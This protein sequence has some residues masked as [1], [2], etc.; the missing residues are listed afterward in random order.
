MRTIEGVALV[1]GA[2]AG[3]GK[4]AALALGARGARVAVHYMKS[5]DGAEDVVSALK[6]AGTDAHAFQG[7]LTK[8]AGVQSLVADVSKRFGA[9]DVLVNNTGDL[10]ERKPLLEMSLE[11]FQ[12][13][14]DV[15]LTSTFL[16]CRAVAP[17]MVART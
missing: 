1:T 15:N 17:G 13:V 12:A 8:E 7:D 6:A 16:M 5:R 11:L 14:M 9:I 2:G 4:A 3:L 10:I